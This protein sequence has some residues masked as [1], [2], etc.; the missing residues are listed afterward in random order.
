MSVLLADMS[1]W[2]IGFDCHCATLGRDRYASFAR[3]TS[4]QFVNINET[5]PH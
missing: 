3:V 1:T 5:V 2:Q 4:F